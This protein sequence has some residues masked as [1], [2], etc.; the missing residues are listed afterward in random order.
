MVRT[1]PDDVARWV[2]EVVTSVESGSELDDLRR[3]RVTGA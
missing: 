1:H 2:G 3:L